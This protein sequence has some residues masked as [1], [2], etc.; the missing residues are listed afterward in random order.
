MPKSLK[1]YLSKLRKPTPKF[2]TPPNPISS[3]TSWILSGCK[4]PRTSSSAFDR[5]RDDASATLSDIHQ[6]LY[7]NFNSL[8]RNG[9]DDDGKDKQDDHVVANSNGVLLESPRFI[10]TPPDLRA[11]LRFFVSPGL[12]NSLIEEAR[13]S[14]S[15]EVGS[16]S[17]TTLN[18]P[19]TVS[20]EVKEFTLSDDSIPVLMHSSDPYDDFRQSMQ[21]MVEARLHHHETVDWDFM[22]DLLFCYLKLNEKQ[23]YKYILSAFIDLMVILGGNSGKTPAK[24][25]KIPV[26]GERRRRKGD[27]T[28]DFVYKIH[29]KVSKNGA[30]REGDTLL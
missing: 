16:N 29:T 9:D 10:D 22:E 6:F 27:V 25:E 23:S 17:T 26:T 15:E 3:S 2:Q 24:S 5:R 12:S 11:S 21:E 20:N 14:V 4:N 7:K 8:Y 18:E 1:N 19:I 28:Y 30:A 13:M